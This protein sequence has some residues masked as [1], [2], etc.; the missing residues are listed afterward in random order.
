[1]AGIAADLVLL[2]F[3]LLLFKW[4]SVREPKKLLAAIFLFF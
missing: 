1:M 3:A 4:I 2:I